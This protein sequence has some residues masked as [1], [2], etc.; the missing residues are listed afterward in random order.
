VVVM[1]LAISAPGFMLYYYLGA[2]AVANGEIVDELLLT[3]AQTAAFWGIL[4]A[5]FGYVI[6][7]RSI[8]ASVFTLNPFSNPWLLGGIA[9]STLIRFIPTL[10]PEAAALF[11]TAPFPLDWWPLI[12]LCFLPSFLA[13]EGDKLLRKRWLKP[14]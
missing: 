6:S 5:H 7:A 1:G 3:Q 12:L 10:I 2:G 9:L 8:Y 14:R 13:I 4:M 11:R